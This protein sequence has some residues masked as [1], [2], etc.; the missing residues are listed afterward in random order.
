MPPFLH[1]T[2]LRDEVASAIAPKRDGVY[3]DV[4]LGGGGHAEA[5]LSRDPNCRLLGF[6]RDPRALAAAGDRLAPFGDRVRLARASF[7]DVPAALHVAEVVAVD[8]IVADLGVSSPQ[9]DDAERGFSIVRDGPLDMRMGPD[10]ESVGELLDRLSEDELT[11]VFLR[12]GEVRPARRL[13]TAVLE[14][15]AAG[16]MTTTHE[17]AAVCERVLGR[18]RSHHPATLPFQALRIVAND[19]LGQLERLLDAAPALLAP[20]GTLAVITFHSLEDRLVKERFRTLSTAP[21]PP[22][23]VP[24]VGDPPATDFRRL[25]DVTPSDAE[26]AANPRARS[27]RLR[28]LQRVSNP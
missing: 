27:A 18:G 28:A 6:D 15:R 21:A 2:I 12:F 14:A 13:A 4:T 19:E 9:L 17:L 25:R 24:F 16:G 5:I 3:V 22:R 10:A 20:G 11:H 26:L 8:G 23:G 7:D 1:I